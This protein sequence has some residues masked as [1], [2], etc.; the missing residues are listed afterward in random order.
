MQR[1]CVVCVCPCVGVCRWVGASFWSPIAASRR[2]RHHARARQRRPST[3][4]F[5]TPST[6]VRDA[7]DN[8]STSA[9]QLQSIACIQAITTSPAIPSSLVDCTMAALAG[10]ARPLPPATPACRTSSRQFSQRP[11][12]AESSAAPP[13]RRAKRALEA[14]EE[15]ARRARPEGWAPPGPAPVGAADDRTPPI[16]LPGETLSYLSGDWRIFQLADGHRWSIDDH[17]TALVA[18]QEAASWRS[19][20]G[21]HRSPTG[22]TAAARGPHQRPPRR[23]ARS[24]SA[25]ASEASC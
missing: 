17:V 10:R 14:P 13:I 3:L 23:C 9:H 25:A 8:Q 21:G 4:F 24:T 20:G 19:G 12:I 1:D 5:L 11:A 2:R 15:R 22:R 16:L 7:C 6:H 18:L